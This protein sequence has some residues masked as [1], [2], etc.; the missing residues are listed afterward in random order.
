MTTPGLG[1]LVSIASSMPA[2]TQR[3]SRISAVEAQIGVLPVAEEAAHLDVGHG[4]RA[5]LAVW[6]YSIGGSCDLSSRFI[7]LEIHFTAP[8]IRP[9]M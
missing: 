7:C 2:S 5:E 8:A 9:R 3:S 4:Q 6:S 1:W